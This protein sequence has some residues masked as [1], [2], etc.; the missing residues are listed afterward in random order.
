MSIFDLYIEQGSTFNQQLTMEGDYTGV[1][2]ACKIKVD[3]IEIGSVAS[4]EDASLGV[5][6]LS[7]T[8]TQTATLPTGVGYYDVELTNA[9]VVSKPMKGRVYVDGEVTK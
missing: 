6:N 4:W 2:I 9:G 3:T 8:A 7:L 1:T 5:F